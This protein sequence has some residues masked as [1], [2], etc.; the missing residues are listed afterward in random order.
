M[1]QINERQPWGGEVQ[2]IQVARY[3]ALGEQTFGLKLEQP[4]SLKVGVDIANRLPVMGPSGAGKSTFL[5]LL[6]C[7]SFP[8]NLSG[9]VSWTFP[10]GFSCQWGN[11]GPGR[12]MLIRLRQRYFGYAFQTASLQPQLTIGENLTFGL[13]NSGRCTASQARRR[14]HD[15]LLKAF[16][17]EE[18]RARNIFDRYDTEISGGERQRISLMQAMIR[19]PYVLFADEPT[20]SLDVDTRAQVMQVLTDW[21]EES[22]EKRLLIWVTHHESDP[23]DNDATR[24]LFVNSQKI[25]FQD[26]VGDS[27]QDVVQG[28]G[29]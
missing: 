27:W 9:K 23:E 12:D 6:S 2:D 20:G 4:L 26:K 16:S 21:L 13:E 15:V 29:V 3:N 24:R 19:D 22:P 11:A 18:R 14:A 28:V 17:G 1:T 8:Q 5:N 7:T 25:L 10:D